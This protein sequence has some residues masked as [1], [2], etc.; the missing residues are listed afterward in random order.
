MKNKNVTK[1]LA[2]F[3]AGSLFAQPVYAVSSYYATVSVGTVVQLPT[4]VAIKSGYYSENEIDR[5]YQEDRN[6]VTSSTSDVTS[7]DGKLIE[8]L[9]P[10]LLD[11][12]N[13]AEAGTQT[14]KNTMLSDEEYEK[15]ISWYSEKIFKEYEASKQQAESSANVGV[16]VE[17]EEI[18][19]AAEKAMNGVNPYTGKAYTSST[20]KTAYDEIKELVNKY[21]ATPDEI[22]QK[23]LD[24]LDDPYAGLPDTSNTTTDSALDIVLNESVFNLA[25]TY[26]QNYVDDTLAKGSHDWDMVSHV[27][28][29]EGVYADDY[30]DKDG[31]E[32]V[33]DDITDIHLICAKCG[34]KY[35]FD[36]YCACGKILFCPYYD[37]QDGS[38]FNLS[39]LNYLFTHFEDDGTADG[40]LEGAKYFPGQS[41][42]CNWCRKNM[43]MDNL[44]DFYVA[45]DGI[46]V[47]KDCYEHELEAYKTYEG[48]AIYYSPA[49]DEKEFHPLIQTYGVS[50][51]Y[52][53]EDTK[54]GAAILEQM[55]DSIKDENKKK[56]AQTLVNV[57]KEY[58]SG[59]KSAESAIKAMKSYANALTGENQKNQKKIIN[60]QITI[61][62]FVMNSNYSQE[63]MLS[64]ISSY[65]ATVKDT[66]N[67]DADYDFTSELIATFFEN[68]MDL[69]TSVDLMY[70]Y[71]EN[72]I[73]KMESDESTWDNITCLQVVDGDNP[74]K[75]NEEIVNQAVS[76][77]SDKAKKKEAEAFLAIFDLSGKEDTT[78]D[79]VKGALKNYISA[80]TN[81]E[82]KE[83]LN[84]QYSFCESVANGEVTEK[85]M[86][87]F[88]NLFADDM[89]SDYTTMSSVVK[90]Y[91][92]GD[93]SND[94]SVFEN[95]L[96]T[97]KDKETKNNIKSLYKVLEAST[98][99]DP[100]TDNA[101]DILKAY[102][103]CIADGDMET[104]A[105]NQ[106]AILQAASGSDVND[107]YLSNMFYSFANEVGAGNDFV[108]AMQSIYYQKGVETVNSEIFSN[109]TLNLSKNS[110]AESLRDILFTC[111][112][113]GETY[114]YGSHC[115]CGKTVYNE[116][117]EADSIRFDEYG[118]AHHSESSASY[119]ACT[120]CGEIMYSYNV[121]QF[122]AL[123]SK[124]TWYI[125][126]K[127]YEAGKGSFEDE[128]KIKPVLNQTA[129]DGI[130]NDSYK[131]YLEEQY[132]PLMNMQSFIN[133]YSA[134][135]SSEFSEYTS[136]SYLRNKA[137]EIY[138]KIKDYSS[139]S[140][141]LPDS[142]NSKDSD[143]SAHVWT[144]EEKKN[145][146]D[147]I[148]EVF[149][150]GV[151]DSDYWGDDT[152]RIK[153]SDEYE[154][155]K[156]KIFAEWPQDRSLWTD[157][158]EK[159]YQ[160]FCE[161]YGNSKTLED[162][163]NQDIFGRDKTV[164]EVLSGIRKYIADFTSISDNITI[165]ATI[166]TGNVEN[167]SNKKTYNVQGNMDIGVTNENGEIEKSTIT[168][169][170][171]TP[172]WWTPSKEGVYSINR[173]V[174]YYQITWNIATVRS[175]IRLDAQ[176][177]D[178]TTQ[179]L[180][181][182]EVIRIVE[183]KSGLNSSTC[184]LVSMDPVYVKV[185][186]G[187]L[188]IDT[189]D[190]YDTERIK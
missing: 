88:M 90:A 138:Q 32:K 53:D 27:E 175:V 104:M 2:I 124:S 147:A 26:I 34:Q 17:A 105:K 145:F 87:S 128:D 9:F 150:D 144:D 160:E 179:L 33:N 61:F 188:D 98:G 36:T 146:Y 135:S 155:N 140:D 187:N 54:D 95:Y 161:K 96:E 172:V 89:G 157:E 131:K 14:V 11:S 127:C 114:G 107:N 133:Q 48:T 44:M 20:E 82:Q 5:L 113:C 177:P 154:E 94:N 141:K 77:I 180:T 35:G 139:N 152:P 41:Y 162:M 1:I 64:A 85:E 91:F 30:F 78:A 99:N 55:L 109:D 59:D 125:C 7:G 49:Y 74:S 137:A 100:D 168:V 174:R 43:T 115:K 153:D 142:M 24:Y 129:I 51:L 110:K 158:Q 167:G 46:V 165:T 149:N 148:T 12:A 21:G 37:K 185:G 18:L 72:N 10:G 136:D 156:N 173:N 16:K 163:I 42:R 56:E 181:Q 116:L 164:D 117:Y 4:N 121:D 143:G 159:I 15:F 106:L 58:E 63:S 130:Y 170:Y 112:T 70:Q 69:N 3:L 47:C 52:Y 102:I 111:S 123:P 67:V 108:E 171:S 62:E 86:L 28:L 186:P 151:P 92:N 190:F 80:M 65:T 38:L 178:G 75:T 182:T 40:Y 120:S 6:A 39:Y 97:I 29:D 66:K 57:F 189:L 101:V 132:A 84:S 71:Y 60:N 118:M 45:D 73:K 119:I 103:N 25:K 23:F 126:S 93:Y 68:D 79:D 83:M 184:E 81:E 134:V 50:G 169:D 122:Y 19:K 183:D 76:G 31:Y 13:S 166:D 176:M 22:Y 8:S